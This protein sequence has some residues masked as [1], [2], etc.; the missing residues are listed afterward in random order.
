MFP[1]PKQA[2]ASIRYELAS[3]WLKKAETLGKV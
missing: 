3:D 2:G 1:C